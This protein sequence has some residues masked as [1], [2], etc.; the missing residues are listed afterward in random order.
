MT[1]MASEFVDLTVKIVRFVDDYQPG[2]VECEFTDAAGQP[3]RLIDKAPIFTTAT[4]S[5]DSIYPQLGAVRCSLLR[6]WQDMGG[7]KLF[8]ISTAEPF[9]IETGEG[10]T[11]FDLL[12]SQNFA[13]QP[14]VTRVH[15]QPAPHRLRDVRKLFRR[16]R[17]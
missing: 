2:I 13:N 7:R 6:V 12:R 10:L 9:S 5:A 4:L 15:R 3:H 8:T 1:A 17:Y 16:S 14:A 11:E